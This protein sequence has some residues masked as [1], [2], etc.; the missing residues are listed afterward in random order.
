[1]A[2]ISRASNASGSDR[3]S[4]AHATHILAAS[5]LG[6]WLV[7]LV[8]MLSWLLRAIAPTEP[9][10]IVTIIEAPA[11][12]PVLRSLDPPTRTL[13]ASLADVQADGSRLAAQLAVLDNELKQ[14]LVQ[15]K[16]MAPPQPPPS[17][18]ADRWA[19]KDLSIL[20]GCWY[21][22]R[23]APSVRGEIG[24]LYREDCTS[25]VG[26]ICFDANGQGRREQTTRCPRAGTYSCSA[27]VVAQFGADGSFSTL[28]P[29]VI[30]QGG[31]SPTNWR[32]RTLT[33]R[34]ID[35]THA[36]CRDSG[37]PELGLPPQDQEFRR[38]L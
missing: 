6:L 36:A 17:L 18:P 22:G 10:T 25:K 38:A 29:D 35:D 30:C 8:L 24:N 15:C 26:R 3:L 9:S 32:S 23:E 2:A 1:M 28:Q 11:E 31:S 37:R 14:R 33:C 21:L 27:P 12:P 13:K 34:R 16:P 19:S 5:L 7:L 4:S 20:Q